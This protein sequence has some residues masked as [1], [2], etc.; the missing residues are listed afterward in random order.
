MV[1]WGLWAPSYCDLHSER[2]PAR[3]GDGAVR[4]RDGFPIVIHRQHVDCPRV[5]AGAA[6]AICSQDVSYHRKGCDEAVVFGW[7]S[8]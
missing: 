5:G 6:V 4:G 8:V 3:V 1:A 7:N 2:V